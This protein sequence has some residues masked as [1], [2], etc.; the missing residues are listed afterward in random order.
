MTATT[1]YGLFHFGTAGLAVAS[2]TMPV[3]TRQVIPANI[4]RCF[5]DTPTFGLRG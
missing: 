5:V 2:A 1:D 3:M 4:F